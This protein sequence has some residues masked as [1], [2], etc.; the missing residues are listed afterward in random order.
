MRGKE[1]KFCRRCHDSKP[2]LRAYQRQTSYN[3]RPMTW[4]GLSAATKSMMNH[5][6]TKSTKNADS[7]LRVLCVLVDYSGSRRLCIW[8]GIA[9]DAKAAKKAKAAK[10]ARMNM[11][12]GLFGV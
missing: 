3:G 12:S 6:D 8:D 9:F 5:E 4:R 2:L 1:E 7:P 10:G 11:G